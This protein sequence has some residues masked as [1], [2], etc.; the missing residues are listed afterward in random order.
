MFKADDMHLIKDQDPTY[1][2]RYGAV[3]RVESIDL[4]NQSRNRVF[5][6]KSDA[7]KYFKAITA[8]YSVKDNTLWESAKVDSLILRG[9]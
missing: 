5:T 9:K 8:E 6:A 1:N 3:Y 4:N 2:N 7:I